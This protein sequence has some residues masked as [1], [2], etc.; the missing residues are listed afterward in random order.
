MS[1]KK[2]IGY[3]FFN[4]VCLLNFGRFGRVAEVESLILEC[5]VLIRQIR[6]GAVESIVIPESISLYDV[7]LDNMPKVFLP[8][9]QPILTEFDVIRHQ[10]NSVDCAKGLF[11][12]AAI[13]HF[14]YHHF[15]EELT[16]TARRVQKRA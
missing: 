6:I 11:E 3:R 1:T 10:I 16:I 13:L 9:Q 8:A 5:Q 14:A 15:R 4:G 2:R 7:T 12:R